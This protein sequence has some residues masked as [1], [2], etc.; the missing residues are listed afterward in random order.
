[1][2]CKK[3]V[4]SNTLCPPGA[5]SKSGFIDEGGVRKGLSNGTVD[6]LCWTKL[7]YCQSKT[8]EEEKNYDILNSLIHSFILSLL[9]YFIS[10]QQMFLFPTV[11]KFL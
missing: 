1:M 6:Q 5:G 3:V 4:G 10:R 11:G 7:D 2:Y 8:I 9:I